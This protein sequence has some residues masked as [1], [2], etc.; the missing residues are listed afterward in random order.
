VK[1]A[2]ISGDLVLQLKLAQEELRI[3]QDAFVCSLSQILDLRD[4]NTGCHSTRLAEW[5]VRVA[6]HL[7]LDETDQRNVEVACLL[8]DLGKVGVP[9]SILRKVGP[10][11]ADEKKQM[12]KHPEYAWTIFRLFPNLERAGLF[13]LHHH[14]HFDGS[15]YP[16]GLRG[17]EI[18]AGAR[19]V[20]VVDSFDAMVSD[21]CY[22]KGMPLDEALRRLVAG[23]GTQFDPDIVRHFV[24]MAPDHLPDVKRIAEPARPIQPTA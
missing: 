17:E 6:I 10:L 4:L 1:A 21:R 20:S 7:G 11:T 23:A 22:R 16:G 24:I 2:A 3:S 15:G 12:D 19:I 9:D 14:E 8:H 18:P 5:A 13:A